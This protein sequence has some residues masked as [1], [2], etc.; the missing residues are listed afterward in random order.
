MKW[1]GKYL[2]QIL[3]SLGQDNVII[4]KSFIHDISLKWPL[5][6]IYYFTQ[7]FNDKYISERINI[8]ICGIVR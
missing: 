1:Q 2:N 8:D 4:K 6:C 3:E 7:K 5:E